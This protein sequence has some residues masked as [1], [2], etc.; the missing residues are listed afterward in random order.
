LL[1]NCQPYIA[2]AHQRRSESERFRSADSPHSINTAANQSEYKKGSCLKIDQLSAVNVSEANKNRGICSQLIRLHKFVQLCLC[3][4]IRN[5]FEFR[6]SQ[7]TAEIGGT[8]N[9][10]GSECKGWSIPSLQS[11]LLILSRFDCHSL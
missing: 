9:C 3:I 7:L 10:C 11:R 5:N 6:Q 4:Q 1:N 2:A 8:R